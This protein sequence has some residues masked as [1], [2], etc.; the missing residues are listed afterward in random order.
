MCQCFMFWSVRMQ[1]GAET[2]ETP[3]TDVKLDMQKV[4]PCACARVLPV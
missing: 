4:C 3:V 2:V 1:V